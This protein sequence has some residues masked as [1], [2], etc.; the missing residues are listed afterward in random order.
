MAKCF[1]TDMIECVKINSDQGRLYSVWS[2]VT[3]HIHVIAH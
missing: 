2:K 1:F 3:A